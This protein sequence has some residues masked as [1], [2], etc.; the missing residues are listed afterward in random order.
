I[1]GLLWSGPPTEVI[2]LIRGK[3]VISYI[4]AELELELVTT[5]HRQKL[6]LRLQQRR[7]TAAGLAAIARTLSERIE[8]GKI[9]VDQLRDPKDEK[10]L[11]TAK[12]ATAAY[13]I[14]GDQD[15]LVLHPFEWVEILT[16]AQF[17]KLYSNR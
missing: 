13:L 14:T 7:Q 11:A 8:I 9:V 2:Q 16:P 12:A 1:S 17:L 6:Q 15:L 4:S 10:I 3:K 5:L